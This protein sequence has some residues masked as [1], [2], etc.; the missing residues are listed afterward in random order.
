LLLQLIH[1]LLLLLLDHLF[2]LFLDFRSLLS[3]IRLAFPL[4]LI[5]SLQVLLSPLLLSLNNYLFLLNL[6]L[7][8]LTSLFLTTLYRVLPFFLLRLGL[9]TSLSLTELRRI[10]V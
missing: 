3:R 2:Q 7:I 6:L 1:L 10:R 8:V 4:L 9:K 5:F